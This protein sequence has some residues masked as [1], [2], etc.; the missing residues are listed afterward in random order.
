MWSLRKATFLVF[1]ACKYHI[2]VI[3]LA[4]P[5]SV[6]RLV[7]TKN[8]FSLTFLVKPTSFCEIGV[9]GLTLLYLDKTKW[10]KNRAPKARTEIFCPRTFW[11]VATSLDKRL[12][13]VRK[14]KVRCFLPLPLYCG[15]RLITV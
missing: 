2:R 8:I 4:I 9:S 3:N 15:C 12:Q 11:T 1:M 5:T 6:H 13:H 10:S 14:R 7:F